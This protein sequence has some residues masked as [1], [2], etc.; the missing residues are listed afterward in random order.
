MRLQI[1][2]LGLL[3]TVAPLWVQAQPWEFG[4]PITV[5]STY[6]EKI[7]HHLESSGRRNIAISADTVA[8]VWEDDRDGTPRIYLALKGLNKQEFS[9]DVKISGGGEAYEPSLV[10]LNNNRFALAWEEDNRIQLRVVT[11]TE[12]GPIITLAKDESMQPSLASHDQQLLLV[13]SKREGRYGRIW[14]QRIEID[15]QTL[16]L[17]QG[18]AVDAEPARDEQLYPTITRLGDRVI[19]AWEDRRPI[20]SSWQHKMITR[21]PAAFA[22]HNESA[23]DRL[24]SVLLSV[25]GMV[26]PELR[27]LH[28]V[29]GSYSPSGPI[30]VIF[31]RV[32]IFI[33]PN[34]N[35]ATSNCSAP[36]SKCKTSLV[37]LPSNGMQQRRAILTAG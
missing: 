11:P 19:V 15:G 33:P 5:T 4:K 22:C 7:F 14:M 17:K 36:T 34:I 35:L 28:T 3:L 12:L 6:G 24:P 16:H 32:M 29:P 10:A 26:W 23:K 13:Y 21:S 9:K 37:V 18:C 8:V 31:A 2:W 20:P 25:W 27:S 1:V 30:S